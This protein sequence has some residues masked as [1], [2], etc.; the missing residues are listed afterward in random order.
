METPTV[1]LDRGA[2]LVHFYEDEEGLVAAVAA[3]LA[4][5]IEAD[6]GAVAIVTPS[7]AAAIEA[8]L[9]DL[10]VDTAA[11]IERGRLSIA[12]AAGTLARFI[13][14]GKP[15]A[16][17]F[18]H[19]IAPFVESAAGGS[20]GATPHVYGEMV[21]CLWRHGQV[22]AA[23]ELEELWNRLAQKLSFTLYCSYPSALVAGAH[24]GAELETACRAH[25]D[26]RGEGPLASRSSERRSFLPENGSVCEARRFVGA[27]LE[28]Q[29]H[30]QLVA[31]ASV[32][33]SELASNAV[34]H[35]GTH[36]S[37]S[38]ATLG[39]TVRVSVRDADPGLPR[40]RISRATDQTGRGL[41]IVESL[42]AAWGVTPHSGGK[43]VWAEFSRLSGS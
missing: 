8:T 12:D 37:V 25:S 11:A 21:S 6:E 39:E 43:T 41:L 33:V 1:D 28:R 23:L 40:R 13:R 22:T 2:H 16:R 19:T 7:H 36:Y 4:D 24:L 15:D 38:V 26:V 9:G 42:N 35:A 31:A 30:P 27:A 10:G 3:F 18:E 32:V 29:G 14:E 20:A 5:G 34:A 17:R